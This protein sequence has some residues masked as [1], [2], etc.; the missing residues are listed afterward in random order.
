MKLLYY[1]IE[2]TYTY[3]TKFPYYPDLVEILQ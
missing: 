2:K 1:K 3:R